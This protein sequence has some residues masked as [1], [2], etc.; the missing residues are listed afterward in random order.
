M[1]Y[2]YRKFE[3]NLTILCFYLAEIKIA[4]WNKNSET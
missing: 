4:W 3:R 1:K 2:Y